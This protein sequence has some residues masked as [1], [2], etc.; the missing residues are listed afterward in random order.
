[1]TDTIEQRL[2][3]NPYRH[4]SGWEGMC[5]YLWASIN[6]YSDINNILSKEIPQE[7]SI[8][9][10]LTKEYY[11][12]RIDEGRDTNERIILIREIIPR[13]MDLLSED[14]KSDLEGL[15]KKHVD[16]DRMCYIGYSDLEGDNEDTS[17]ICS[18]AKYVLSCLHE[19]RKN[20]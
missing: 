9:H 5:N 8:K 11:R 3:N 2:K 13:I 15:L 16:D 18:A 7:P 1:M 4:T 20:D 6:S 14:E 19:S 10:G 12:K 17:T